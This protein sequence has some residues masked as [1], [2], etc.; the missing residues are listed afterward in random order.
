M[1]IIEKKQYEKKATVTIE[2]HENNQKITVIVCSSSDEDGD[3][4]LNCKITS[5]PENLQLQKGIHVMLL[6]AMFQSLHQIFK[7]E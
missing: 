3:N 4:C 2:N 7:D 6:D 5:S 1:S